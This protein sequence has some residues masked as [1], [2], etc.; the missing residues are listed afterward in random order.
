[1]FQ[2]IDIP[3]VVVAESMHLQPRAVLAI[4]HVLAVVPAAIARNK[5]SLTLPQII[6]QTSLIESAVA[7]HHD[8]YTVALAV[9]DLS[10]VHL[11]SGDAHRS[12]ILFVLVDEATIVCL[13]SDCVV[14][15]G[16]C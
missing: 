9:V 6:F 2:P 10:E 5:Q 15:G 3:T 13:I 12:K 7:K 16:T 8:A 1:M 4:I 14:I 11:V